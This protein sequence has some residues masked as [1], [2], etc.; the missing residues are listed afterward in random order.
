[1]KLKNLTYRNAF[2]E[3]GTFSFTALDTRISVAKIFPEGAAAR[4]L[5]TVLYG[6]DERDFSEL[7][8]AEIILEFER[9]EA[10]YRL[11]RAYRDGGEATEL[12]SEEG[13]TTLMLSPKKTKEILSA[14][15]GRKIAADTGASEYLKN[16][17]SERAPSATEILEKQ[18]EAEEKRNRAEEEKRA[19]ELLSERIGIPEMPSIDL[20]T[21]EEERESV[22]AQLRRAAEKERVAKEAQDAQDALTEFISKNGDVLR[23]KE[24]LDRD[25]R[26]RK[27]RAA[28]EKR[29]AARTE[30]ERLKSSLSELG[31]KSDAVRKKAAG[32]DDAEKECEADFILKSERVNALRKKFMD[33]MCAADDENSEIRRSLDAYYA[34]NDP[35]IQE[36]R[37]KK[38]RLDNEYEAL[39]LSITS[40]EN[41]KKGL[42]RPMSYKKAVIDGTVLE[43]KIEKLTAAIE[44][45]NRRSGELQLEISAKE[46][47]IRDAEAEF[48]H[49]TLEKAELTSTL[50]KGKFRTLEEAINADQALKNETYAA[51][52]T[53]ENLTAEITALNEK[54]ANLKRQNEENEE[55]R[56]ELQNAKTE[57]EV[58]LVKLK[59]KKESFENEYRGKCAQNIFAE[60]AEKLRFGDRCPVCDSY[61]VKKNEIAKTAT[62]ATSE[63]IR[64][65]Q[66]EIVENEKRLD[67]ILLKLGAYLS[68]EASGDAYIVSL[69]NTLIKKESLLNRIYR[70]FGAENK[71]EFGK[72]I[73]KIGAESSA[74]NEGILKLNE[75]GGSIAAEAEKKNVLQN[76]VVQ[77]SGRESKRIR[78]IVETAQTELET[79]LTEY[80]KLMP[81][82]GGRPAKELLSGSLIDDIE[83]ETVDGDLVSQTKNFREVTVQKIETDRILILLK[84][85]L[86][87]DLK[88]TEAES[89]LDVAL[90]ET[91]RKAKESSQELDEAESALEDAKLKLAAVRRVNRNAE[92]EIYGADSNAAAIRLKIAAAET[93]AEESDAELGKILEE[94]GITEEKLSASVLSNAERNKAEKTLREFEEKKQR[95]EYRAEFTAS[96]PVTLEFIDVEGLKK[97]GAELDKLAADA[98]VRIAKYEY[99]SETARE[100]TIER[101]ALAEKIRGAEAEK[102]T[103]SVWAG[104]LKDGEIDFEA[105]TR[106]AE[107]KANAVLLQ[108]SGGTCETV[109]DEVLKKNQNLSHASKFASE[110]AAAIL[111]K[112]FET[113]SAFLIGV[114]GERENDW[115]ARI[116]SVAADVRVAV[117]AENKNA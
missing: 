19:V 14:A 60:E 2:G 23:L 106:A 5:T 107:E 75:L 40:L 34:A 88:D 94:F 66:T 49:K 81:V 7:D 117:F 108:L 91:S 67:R 59:H 79:A 83:L 4:A 87:S 57:I 104:A 110:L 1:M 115:I 25:D 27:A 9:G 21:I 33:E 30:A 17:L 50:L 89:A 74:F 35:R 24:M 55:K 20:K 47:D 39:L 53:A 68:T 71:E 43:Y 58:R 8:N 113:H 61:V 22:I 13:E 10:V 65:V 95:L 11:T 111:K 98:A 64:K 76:A 84:N 16:A 42:V 41:K 63:N 105:L 38:K 116:P 82:F 45:G 99:L 70:G 26:L 52:V 54:I 109:E 3:D 28:A 18:R 56:K 6:A 90:R 31:S 77:L 80:R 69:Q 12:T 36:L 78:A 92:K 101:D 112:P 86:I 46:E 93:A 103:L 51:F 72:A 102:E 37:Q 15:F 97:R 114:F 44:D 73:E 85:K 48:K 32:G 62:E 29:E 100:L 96:R